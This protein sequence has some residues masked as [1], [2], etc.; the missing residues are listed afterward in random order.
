MGIFYNKGHEWI[1]IEG[2][3]ATIGITKYAVTQLGDITFVDL[4]DIGKQVKVSES[5]CEIE[6]VKAASDIYAPL[7]GEISEINSGLVISPGLI[8]QNPETEGWIFKLKLGSTPD[9]SSLMDE[10]SYREYIEKL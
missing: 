6:S 7:D 8:T 5:I 2:D 4:P 1:S 9:T 3:T 10:S